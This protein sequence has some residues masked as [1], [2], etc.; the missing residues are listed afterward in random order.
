VSHKPVDVEALMESIRKSGTK[1]RGPRA[2]K[3]IDTTIR[4]LTLF[5]K[6]DRENGVCDNPDCPDPR[7]G[8]PKEVN[9]RVVTIRE[10]KMCRHCFLAG[11][12][13]E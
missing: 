9:I 3:E 7:R 5:F 12:G 1:R 4:R 6:M 2:K 10:Y 11:F 13:G 8:T